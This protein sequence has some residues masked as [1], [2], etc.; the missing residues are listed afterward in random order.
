M[1]NTAW[2]TQLYHATAC[3]GVVL[4]TANLRL[5]PKDLTY[6][7]RHAQDQIMFVDADLVKLLA[8]VEAPILSDIQLFVIAGEDAVPGKFKIPQQI[9]SERV[10]D[11]A[12]FVSTSVASFEWPDFKET[13]LHAI[14]YTSGTTGNPKAA[15]YSHR[16]TY[17]HTIAA[18]GADALGLKGSHVVLPFVPMFHVLS[19][20]VPFMALML[21]TRMIMNNRFM[22]PASLLQCFVDWEVQL[23]TGV[24]VAGLLFR[25]LN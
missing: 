2:H 1:W 19:W 17:L 16:S 5:G 15:A 12:A 9:P 14:C 4:H 8:A 20:G 23:S 11:L 24:P 18:V 10:Q 13:T 6:C 21:G 7:I 22:D 3:L 25:N